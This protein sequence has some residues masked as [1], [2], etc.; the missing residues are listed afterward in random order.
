[1]TAATPCSR[2]QSFISLRTKLLMNTL[3]QRAKEPTI[4]TSQVCG[5]VDRRGARLSIVTIKLHTFPRYEG[6]HGRTANGLVVLRHLKG[7]K[8]GV[9]V[10]KCR[11]DMRVQEKSCKFRRHIQLVWSCLPTESRSRSL[12]CDQLAQ[13][14]NLDPASLLPSLELLEIVVVEVTTDEPVSRS[15]HHYLLSKT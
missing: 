14:L 3:L 13:I 6:R 15:V 11:L 8:Q 10:S 12:P 1:M 2:R 7:R 9:M 4:T 5:D